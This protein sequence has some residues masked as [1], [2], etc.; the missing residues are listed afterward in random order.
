MHIILRTVHS[1]TLTTAHNQGSIFSELAGPTQHPGPTCRRPMGSLRPKFVPVCT[2]PLR[3]V[4]EF[5][6]RPRTALGYLDLKFVPV[7]Y[8]IWP[9]WPEFCHFLETAL[10]VDLGGPTSTWTPTC[11]PTAISK[12]LGSYRIPYIVDPAGSA[13]SVATTIPWH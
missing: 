5:C 10:Q 2:R 13:P 1:R 12:H 3:T 9:F 7:W 6:P 11:S 8:G 4:S